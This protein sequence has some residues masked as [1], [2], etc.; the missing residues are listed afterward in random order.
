MD[1]C[2][3]EADEAGDSRIQQNAAAD[4]REELRRE[5]VAA[6]SAIASLEQQIRMLLLPKDPNEGR[7]V[8]V[9]IRG[10]EGGEEA[11][12]FARD[13]FEMYR[14]YAQNRKWKLTERPMRPGLPSTPQHSCARANRAG[15]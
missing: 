9:E 3:G 14:S 4:E 12:L 8:I 7:N 1:W 2:S 10:A 15:E 11:N 6:E 13:L 5:I